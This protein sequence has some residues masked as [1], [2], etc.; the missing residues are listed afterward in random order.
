VAG[1]AGDHRQQLAVIDPETRSLA[2]YHI[3][4]SSGE[5]SLKSVRNIHYDLRMSEFNGTSPLPREV[6]SMVELK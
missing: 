6:R 1:P 5:I 3:D 2:V 4:T